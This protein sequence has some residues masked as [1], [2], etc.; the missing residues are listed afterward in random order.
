MRELSAS[1]IFSE[2]WRLSSVRNYLRGFAPDV[3]GEL[4]V[5]YLESII[6]RGCSTQPPST[7]YRESHSP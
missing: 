5:D 4:K 1:G 6:V 7:S 3:L 2:G